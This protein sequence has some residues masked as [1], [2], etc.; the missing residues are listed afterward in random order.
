MVDQEGHGG[1]NTGSS[2]SCSRAGATKLMELG[3]L[4]P[5]TLDAVRIFRS[6]TRLHFLR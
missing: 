1:V 6:R 3:W 2:W 5:L 4:L